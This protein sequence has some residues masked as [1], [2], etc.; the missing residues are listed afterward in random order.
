MFLGFL[1]RVV[2]HSQEHRQP[3]RPPR[4]ACVARNQPGN[5]QSQL[6]LGRLIVD[7]LTDRVDGAFVARYAKWILSDDADKEMVRLPYGFWRKFI[8]EEMHLVF[9]QQHRHRCFRALYVYLHRAGGGAATSVTMRAGQRRNAARSSGGSRNST[10]AKGMGFALLQFFVDNIQ[11]HSCR[12][13]STML[14]NKAKELREALIDSGMTEESLPKLEEGAG[15]QWLWRWRREYNIVFKATGMQL[16]VSWRKILR[17]AA[18]YLKNVFRLKFFW[19]LC[20]GDAEMKW[21]S[22]DQKPAWFNNAGHTGTF[23]KRGTSDSVVENFAH[24]RSRYTICTVVQSWVKYSP[25][26]ADDPPPLFVLFKGKPGGRI[27]EEIKAKWQEPSW[28]NLQVQENGSYREQDVIDALHV[29]LPQATDASQSIIVILDWYAGHRTENV[30]EFIHSRGH[31]VIFHGGGCTP[32]T[33]IND[34]HLHARLQRL[35]IQLEN[36]IS[37]GRR[38]DMHLNGRHGLCSLSRVDICSI[39]ATVW[40]MIDHE[41]VASKG[42]EQTGPNLPLE[43]PIRRDQIYSSLR[44]VYDEIDPAVGL[45]EM[46]EK[47]RDDA[48]AF[49]RA[50]FPHK[51][52]DWSHANRLILEHDDETDP[53]PEGMEAFGYQVVGDDEESDHDSPD[54]DDD[55]DLGASSDEQG[56][57]DGAAAIVGQGAGGDEM[58]GGDGDGDADPDAPREP[59]TGA[60]GASGSTDELGLARATEILL[61]DAKKNKDDALYRRLITRR[62][63]SSKEA[64]EAATDVGKLLQKRALDQRVV[65]MAVRKRAREDEHRAKADETLA[66]QR[67]AEAANRIPW[68]R[69]V[70][71][72]WAGPGALSQQR[73]SSTWGGIAAGA[74]LIHINFAQYSLSEH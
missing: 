34:T 54:G 68:V 13:D 7:A 15:W 69:L 16:K 61:A 9:S 73:V 64:I 72:E 55:A 17:R 50:G 71:T 27:I 19:R 36:Q 70:I 57:A 35:L 46:G 53:I 45:Q 39:V 32:F 67:K 41:S 14:L 11:V 51:W 63:Q 4:V 42:Y 47:L 2:G 23:S 8:E 28:F 58:H 48:G 59:A 26:T 40:R 49:V 56:D 38:T 44:D 60:G 22:I 37:H 1:E 29:L 74:G 5:L 12:S 62:N 31:L 20:H 66:A 18:V 52:A 10:K 33:Q 30:M 21:L 6:A 65:D 25:Y 43:G 3:A 24:T